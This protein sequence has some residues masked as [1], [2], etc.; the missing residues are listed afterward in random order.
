MTLFKSL[1]MICKIGELESKTKTEEID[2]KKR[3]VGALPGI[4]FP[5]DFDSLS[6]EEKLRRLDGAVAIGNEVEEE[7]K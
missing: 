1:E 5:A 2:W 3:M 6:D 4:E 7:L